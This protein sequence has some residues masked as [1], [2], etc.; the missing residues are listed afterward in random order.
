MIYMHPREI[1]PAQPRLTLPWPQ[2]FIHYF[3]V[4][5]CE[6]K[7]RRLL[8]TVPGPFLTIAGALGQYPELSAE[9]A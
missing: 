4:Q 2:S 6:E 7:L 8:R 3:G 5:G 1:D 9:P